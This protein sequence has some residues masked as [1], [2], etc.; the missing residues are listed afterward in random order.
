MRYCFDCQ[1]VS[2]DTTIHGESTVIYHD[3]ASGISSMSHEMKGKL[4]LNKTAAIVQF[5]DLLRY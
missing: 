5:A 2:L 4:D 3:I 1:I